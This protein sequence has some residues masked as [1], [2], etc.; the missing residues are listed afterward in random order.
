MRRLPLMMIFVWR[1]LLQKGEIAG[2]EFL[3]DQ[4]KWLEQ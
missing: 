2:G 3:W 1:G 4:D